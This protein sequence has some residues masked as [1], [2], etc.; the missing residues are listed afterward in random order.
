MP[1]LPMA[2][3][4]P[5]LEFSTHFNH[6]ISMDTTGPISPSSNGNSYLNAIIDAFKHYVV[7]HPYSEND[8]ANAI[9]V[10]FIHWMVEFGIPD[11]LVTE[12]RN[13]YINGEFTLFAANTT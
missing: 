3:Q 9:N 2:T 6:R 7:H 13:E 10:L 12:N 11:F 5:F 8:A 1:N 4:L